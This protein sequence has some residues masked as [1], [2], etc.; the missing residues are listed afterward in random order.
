MQKFPRAGAG[1]VEATMADVV[2]AGTT[3]RDEAAI[4]HHL[5][6]MKALGVAMPEKFPF[7]FRLSAG[8]LTQSEHV[9][10]LGADSSGEAEPVI[11]ALDDGLWLTVGS[12]HTDRKVEA[13]SINISKQMCP[14]PIGRH[15]WRRAAV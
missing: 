12:D 10:V 3:A 9:Q 13:Y 5:A 1:A 15:L 11:V 2:V 7:F 8:I 6:E 14:H 4:R